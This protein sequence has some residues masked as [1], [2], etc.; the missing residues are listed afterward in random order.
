MKKFIRKNLINSL[1]ILPFNFR[2][3]IINIFS[4]TFKCKDGMVNN[5]SIFDFKEIQG[6]APNSEYI[7]IYK[8][9]LKRAGDQ[10]TDNIYKLLR[11]L[12]LYSYIEDVLT[13]KIEGDFAECGCWNGN[14]LFATK[15][16]IDKYN[17]NKEIHVFDSFEGGLSDFKEEDIEGGSFYTNEMIQTIRNQFKSSYLK[18]R[19]E[20]KSLKNIYLNKGW[21][22]EV[23]QSQKDR[24]Y[25]FVHVDVDLY[26]PTFESHKYFFERLTKG[27]IIICDDYG[28]KQFPGSTRAVE[29]F[30]D[31]IPR[32]SYSHF[33]KHSFGTSVLIK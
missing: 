26:E 8:R 9:C 31:S 2:E 21:I 11:H 25:S 14:S 28:Y 4:D 27:G 10:K 32:S 19:N 29:K 30:I 1:K 23:F 15:L 20:T 3:K 33:F 17:S 6:L 13:R 5:K 7:E 22:P 24:S 16:L 12:N 18:L